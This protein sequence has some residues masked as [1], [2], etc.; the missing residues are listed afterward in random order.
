M[1]VGRTR[2][3]A[4]S[5]VSSSVVTPGGLTSS[6]TNVPSFQASTPDLPNVEFRKP[7]TTAPATSLVGRLQ[8]AVAGVLLAA[9][10]GTS[11]AQAQGVPV[12]TVALPP[13]E[14]AAVVQVVT[15]EPN[16]AAFNDAM[17]TLEARLA[18]GEITAAQMAQARTVLY[19]VH[20]QGYRGADVPRDERGRITV[21]AVLEAQG[22][23]QGVAMTRGQRVMDQLARDLETR[24]RIT[25]KDMATGNYTPLEGAPGYKEISQ[26][27]AQRL[28]TDA[29]KRMPIGELPGGS[30]LAEALGNLPGAEGL[31]VANM[32]FDELS[33][34]LQDEAKA[35]LKAEVGPFIE[36]HKVESATVAFAAI[37]GLR[38]ASPDA[39]KLMDS[40][41][42]KIRVWKTQ[43]NDGLLRTQ[44]RL[45]YRDANVLPDLDVE[46]QLHHQLNDRT[47]L[48][49]GIT[50]TLSLEGSEHFTGAA[51][52]GAH[53][54]GDNYWV[55]G[56]GA[57]DMKTERWRASL[58]G[59]YV[60]GPDF[61]AVGSLTATFGDGVARGDANG[62]AAL[63]LDLTRDLRFG[64]GVT[65]DIGAYVGASADTDG[66]HTDL[67]AG[68][69]LRLRW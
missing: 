41:G 22:A 6:A 40:L 3:S 53:Y 36:D 24:M 8:P 47:S 2:A 34:A 68:I 59:G 20:V 21:D 50:G 69:M 9:T 14:T 58:T 54:T 19:R 26:Q 57:Y 1:T 38:A 65:G 66:S 43:T 7:T 30:G 39:A 12:Q 44:G 64:N 17:R 62:R 5:Y 51:T 28:L 15:A 46:G 23:P 16:V 52:I 56:A 63:E 49:A 55:D 27:D 32:S 61:R 4:P 35:W 33:R 18:N 37:T 31:D 11:M 45:V 25:A 67:N 29:L 48:R 10:L 13:A 60:P 42:V